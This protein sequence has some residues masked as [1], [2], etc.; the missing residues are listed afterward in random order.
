MP[1][2]KQGG[3]IK[4]LRAR[5]WLIVVFHNVSWIVL[6][7]LGVAQLL[8]DIWLELSLYGT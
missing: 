6:Q 1:V 3:K 5:C 7:G 8:Y 2:R 4:L